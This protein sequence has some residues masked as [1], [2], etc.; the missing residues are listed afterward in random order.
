MPVVEFTID[1][2]HDMV[3]PFSIPS[4]AFAVFQM[5]PILDKENHLINFEKII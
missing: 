5:V 1:R 4:L 2:S 3:F